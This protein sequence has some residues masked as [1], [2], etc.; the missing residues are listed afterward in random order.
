MTRNPHVRP[1]LLHRFID[2]EASGGIVLM[3]AAALALIVAN[4]PLAAIYFAA[5]KT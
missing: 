3:G 2:G 4:S 5:L 1:T